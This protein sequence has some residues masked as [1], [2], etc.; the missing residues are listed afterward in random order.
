M[1]KV[2][3][4]ILSSKNVTKD[5]LKLNASKADYIHI[6]VGDGHFI[7][8]R[9]NPFKT[10][11]KLYPETTKR[12]DVH[13]MNKKP[14]KNINKYA[15]L[16]T[17][18]ITIHVEIDKVDR[19]IDMIKQYGIKCG[20]AI[21]PDT[22][23]EELLPYLHKIDLIIVMSVYPG[24]GGQ[25]FIEDT[26]KKILKIK[27]MIVKEKVDVKITVDGGVNDETSKK[28]DFADILVS[29]SY[30]LNGEDYDERIETIRTNADKLKS[31]KKK[32][33]KESVDEEGAIK[34]EA[35]KKKKRVSK[36]VKE[37]N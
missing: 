32:E 3:V 8:S 2:S 23:V 9:F 16:N 31:K 20:L 7:K 29:G 27:K 6:D 36:E 11:Y 15:L 4:S 1:K 14:K 25:K 37:N 26:T 5:F 22:D 34:N 33:P 28:L 30:I 12:L 35:P 17:E 10:L 24:L 19:Y 18:Y 21:N 13:L